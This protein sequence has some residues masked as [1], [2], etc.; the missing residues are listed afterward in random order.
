MFREDDP[1]LAQEFLLPWSPDEGGPYRE[2]VRQQYTFSP[3][4]G[5][6]R[7]KITASKSRVLE[8]RITP[9]ANGGGARASLAQLRLAEM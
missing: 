8:L 7:S 1:G 2:V 3:R 9:D 6:A 4:A 5:P